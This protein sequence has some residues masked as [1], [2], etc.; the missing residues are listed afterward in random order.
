MRIKLT[1]LVF[2]IGI[3]NIFAQ[4][5]IGKSRSPQNL[6]V[7]EHKQETFDRIKKMETIFF[8]PNS[9]IHNEELKTQIKKVWTFNEITF[10]EEIK[11]DDSEELYD[12][13][14]SYI[15]EDKMLIRLIDNVYSKSKTGGIMGPEKR[16]VGFTISFKFKAFVFD[17]ITKNKKGDLKFD[18]TTIAE[19]FFTPNIRLRQDLAYSVGGKMKIGSFDKINAKYGEEPGFYNYNLGF[20]KNYFQELNQRLLDSQNLK[21]E[22][23]IKKEDKIAELKNKTLYAPEWVLM[24]YNAMAATY[25]KTRTKEDLFGKYEHTYEVLPNADLNEK[26]LEGDDFYYLMHTQFNQKKIIS[27]IHSTTGEIIY[28]TEDGSYNLKD[29]DL[30]DLSKLINKVI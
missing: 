6:Y 11:T 20:V 28:L 30:K 2:A 23:G 22:G 1:M 18:E 7:S 27:V 13:L 24:K 21:I 29:S 14:T 17:N 26:I 25:G 15:S 5:N 12:F 8:I 4:V 10:V 9:I 16:T 3:S 19:M